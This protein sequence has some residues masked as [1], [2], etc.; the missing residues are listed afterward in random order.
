MRRKTN[1]LCILFISLC[2]V[3]ALA[4]GLSAD[5]TR[6]YVVSIQLGIPRPTTYEIYDNE[7]SGSIISSIPLDAND[8]WLGTD[9]RTTVGKIYIQISGDDETW[10]LSTCTKN[11]AI[12]EPLLVRENDSS[13]TV[14]WK[15]RNHTI[16]GKDTD[17]VGTSIPSGDWDSSSPTIKYKYFVNSP[18]GCSNIPTGSKDYAEIATSAYTGTDRIQITFGVDFSSN[19]KNGL[20]GTTVEYELLTN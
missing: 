5:Q 6:D 10:T 12:S 18:T 14:I 9:I 13:N 19:T 4:T 8:V 11:T 20:Y 15:Y 17:P 16:F 3:I 1:I 7:T 2:T